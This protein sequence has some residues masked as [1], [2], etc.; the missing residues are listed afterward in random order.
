VVGEGLGVVVGEGLG[1]VV[2]AGL[3]WG[4]P[5]GAAPSISSRPFAAPVSVAEP[6]SPTGTAIPHDTSRLPAIQLACDTVL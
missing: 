6:R 3:V 4:V 5:A 2:G 1:V